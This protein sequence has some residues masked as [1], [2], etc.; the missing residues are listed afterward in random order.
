MRPEVPSDL[1]TRRWFGPSLVT[2]ALTAIVLAGCGDGQVVAEA[3]PT[4]SVSPSVSASPSPTPSPTPPADRDGDGMPDSTD[5]YP[6]DPKNVP[7]QKPFTI[8]C[9]LDQTLHPVGAAE[10]AAY[11]TSKYDDEEDISTLY[12]ICAEV[13]PDDVYA[14]PGFSASESQISEINGALTLCPKHPYA[15]KWRGAAK[16]G[17]HDIELEAQGRLFGSGTFR[18]GKEIKPGTY[19]THDVDGCY[20]E[21]QNRSGNIIDNYFTNRARR[22]QVT[23]RSS[24]YAFSS[25]RCGEW[26][27][28]S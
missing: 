24:D 12:R 25:Q 17:Q 5:P 22:V 9:D 13:D 8:A 14:E 26:R 3:E 1:P 6:D 4:K 20:W 18:V 7:Q 2:A 28:V 16:R 27:P 15:K 11:K 10:K 23:I 21:R 19:V